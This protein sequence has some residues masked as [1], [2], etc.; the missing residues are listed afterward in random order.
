MYMCLLQAERS[1]L[2]VC[3]TV[4]ELDPVATAGKVVGR[5]RNLTVEEFKK[6]KRQTEP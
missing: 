3:K 6:S 5:K 1:V 4:E 2:K